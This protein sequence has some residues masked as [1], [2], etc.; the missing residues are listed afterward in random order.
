[1][2]ERKR[3]EILNDVILAATFLTDKVCHGMLTGVGLKKITTP[4]R[5]TGTLVAWEK[6]TL[7]VS[8][9]DNPRG[10]DMATS[11]VRTRERQEMCYIYLYSYVQGFVEPPSS[12][13]K[14]R[15]LTV[16]PMEDTQDAAPPPDA[17][18]GDTA[19][20]DV[21]RME[22]KREGPDT[23]TVTL[24]PETKKQR[25]HHAIPTSEHMGETFLAMHQ[26][27]CIIRPED[28]NHEGNEPSTN[29]HQLEPDD[30]RQFLFHMKTPGWMADLKEGSIFRVDASTDAIDETQA[31]E[32]WP[33]VEEADIK[34][35]AQFVNEKA[36]KPVRRQDLDQHCAI[37]DA[38][39]VRKWK[40]M[41]DNNRI[42]KSRLCVRGCHDPWK[43]ELNSRSTTATRLS[44]R[45]ILVTASN[46]NDSLESWDIAGAFL[47]G[48]T[49]EELWKC[50]K[51]LGLNSVERMIAIVPPMNVWRH[52]SK[53]SAEFAIPEQELGDWVL[54]CLKPVYGLSEAPLA[55]Q[56]FLHQYLRELGGHQSKFDECYWFWP[57]KDPGRWPIA[58]LSTHVD[59]LAATSKQQWLDETFIKMV[60]KFG[61]L[62]RQ[63]LPLSHCGCRYSRTP[64]GLKVDQEE[65]VDL[66]KPVQLPPGDEERQL[67]ASETTLL[68]SAIGGLMWAGLTRPDLYAELSF[69]QS[70]MS[71][72]RVRHLKEVNQLVARAK[73]DKEAAI[74]Y[75]PLCTEHYRIV[76]IHDASAATS[77]KNYAQEGVLVF[78]MSDTMDIQ[79]EHIV[80][81]EYFAKECLSGT[82]QLL[83][84]QS[85]K[86]KRV[87][88]STSH[89]E[90]LAAINGLE[91]STLV[92]TR[93]AEITYGGTPPTLKQLLAVQEQGSAYFP[94]DTHTDCR[95]FYELTTGGRNLPQDKSQRLYVMAH[96]EARATGRIRWVILT[97]TECMTADALTKPMQSECLMSWLTTGCVKFWNTGHPLEM[98]RLPAMNSELTEE[99]L[100][101][102]DKVLKTKGQWYTT[103]PL[104]TVSKGA[105]W[106]AMAST[107]VIPVEAQPTPNSRI[108]EPSDIILIMVMMLISIASGALAICCDRCLA[109]TTVPIMTTTTTTTTSA[110]GSPT[111][112]PTSTAAASGASTHPPTSSMPR[113]TEGDIFIRK[114]GRAY[115]TP[116]CVYAQ[117]GF[118]YSPC[119][120]CNPQNRG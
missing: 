115:H 55:W 112:R 33:Q 98:K 46:N 10:T 19:D 76:T 60:K 67:N 85:N 65:Y 32:V 49:Y 75:R 18:R 30:P 28:A 6:G 11:T 103:L 52:L 91:C 1:M 58:S 22:N 43:S 45:M 17:P 29:E 101:E 42:V 14:P 97:P 89:G 120:F 69:L 63:T 41:T 102:G 68:R 31:Y 4:G 104:L 84:M 53:H 80:A 3:K 62:T 116:Q 40:R 7:K 79:Q 72:G 105:F 78:L 82:A 35:I 2:D 9:I 83:H 44:Q 48:L 21:E 57:A 64:G 23:R 66:L 117:G 24:G 110:T 113:S 16:N 107:L 96:R 108:I 100:V 54:L 36:F 5:T 47:K 50:L 114:K 88:Y 61:K 71:K 34:E 119:G 39:W 87:S 109:R 51:R 106:I 8:I 99:D 38:I 73:R 94:V 81:D 26:R 74:H 86:A 95:D 37:I 20:M 92:S 25:V 77:T 15:N 27:Q 70:A 56:L 59:D 12:S 93:L 90:T 13:W 111:T 118:K